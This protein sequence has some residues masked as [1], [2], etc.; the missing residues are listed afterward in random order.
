MTAPATYR[1]EI[2]GLRAV[3]VLP[4]ILYH[5]GVP[6]F[7]GGFVGVDVFFVISG[8]LITGLLLA[9]LDRGRFSIAEFYIRRARRIL[10]ALFL[11]MLCCIPFAWMWMLPSQF[12]SF[13]KSL[14]AVVAFASNILFFLESGY[15]ETSAELKPLLHTWSLAVEEQFYIFFPILLAGL[16]ALARRLFPDAEPSR[17]RR[18]AFATVAALSLCSLAGAQYGAQHFPSANFYLIP[19]RAWEL[20]AGALCAFVHFD[21]TARGSRWLAWAGLALILIAVLSFDETTPFPSLWTLLPVGGTA[22]VV[23]FAAPA[24]G[25]GRLLAWRGCV[26]IGLISYSA[27][28]WHQPIL[29][30]IRLRSLEDP[31]LHWMVLAALLSLPLAWLSWK[32]VEQPFRK[33]RNLSSRRPLWL[34]VFLAAG[35]GLFGVYGYLSK[36][37]P[38]RL[39]FS[40]Q[41]ITDMSVRAFQRPCFNLRRDVD[42]PGPDWFCTKGA[43]DGET[44]VGIWGDSHALSFLGPLHDAATDEG[45]R[46]R[47]SARAGCPPLRDTLVASAGARGATCNARNAAAFSD[48]ALDGIDVAV[49]IGRWTLYTERG[50]SSPMVNLGTEFPI[51]RDAAAT[52]AV[53][54]AQLHETLALFEQRGIPVILLHQPPKQALGSPLVYA[55]AF[56]R[57]LPPSTVIADA[58]L[59]TTAHEAEYGALRAGLEAAL[60]AAA[61]I[62]GQSLD[63]AKILCT[64]TCL[65]GDD[66]RTRYIDND[67]LSNFGASL[68]V[69]ELIDRIKAVRPF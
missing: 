61:P 67:H 24:G 1:P 37:A 3:A 2:D 46:L 53:F 5:A 66:H 29:A 47:F 33:P 40:D 62:T 20:G 16:F 64:E 8:Y 13:A 35:M 18:L 50:P 51:S 60:A 32:F 7:S 49:L 27:Y 11:V 48:A 68:V 4:V 30:F 25:A 41:I 15:F 31:A 12:E 9:D 42:A 57:N 52:R 43:A 6:A 58:S 19:T 45:L 23:L 55:H 59:R 39:N 56:Q 14:V 63:P 17:G 34:A 36:G 65:I 69:P 38:E 26:G 54:F 44:T 22:L 21:R 28:L 10:P